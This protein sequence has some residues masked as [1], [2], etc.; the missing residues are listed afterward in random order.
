MNVDRGL[1]YVDDRVVSDKELIV[2]L[3]TVTY[4][5]IQYQYPYAFEYFPECNLNTMGIT[6]PGYHNTYITLSG[7]ELKEEIIRCLLDPE[8]ESEVRK[9]FGSSP[10]PAL[11]LMEKDDFGY[12]WIIICFINLFLVFLAAV[13]LYSKIPSVINARKS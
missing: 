6:A 11:P 13:V 7:F 2:A 3:G 5:K 9:L 12:I 4:A 10:P 8:R 1:S